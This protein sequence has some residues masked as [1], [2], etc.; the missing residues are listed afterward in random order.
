MDTN[1]KQSENGFFHY[2]WRF[3]ALAIAAA[4]VVCVLLGL[5]VTATIFKP[6]TR[7]RRVTNVVNVSEQ[8]K[9]SEEF[10]LGTPS[11]LAGTDYVR[12]PLYRGQSYGASYYSKSSEQNVVNYL[13]LN[14]STSESRWLFESAGQLLTTSQVLLARLTSP[15]DEQK[16]V[17]MIYAIVER[18]SNGDNRLTERDAISLA[19]SAVGGDQY[20]KLIEGIDRLYSV[21]QITDDKVLVLYQKNRQTVSEFY[22]VPSMARLTQSI[23][24]KVD[25]K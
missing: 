17:A 3:N 10:T 5:F 9:I 15:R 6:E 16:A 7:S 21:E 19:T 8:D 22:S 11:I 20:R 13:F 23:V 25:L 12:V 2:V 1:V 18:D 4:A 14:T 24:P